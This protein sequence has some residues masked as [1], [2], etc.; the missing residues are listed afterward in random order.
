M[1]ALASGFVWAVCFGEASLHRFELSH[2]LILIEECVYAMAHVYY[3]RCH[4]FQLDEKES[5]SRSLFNP[6]AA[7]HQ[8]IAAPTKKARPFVYT[9]LPNGIRFNGNTWIVSNWS[10]FRM[11]TLVSIHVIRHAIPTLYL[12]Y[13]FLYI[14]FTYLLYYVHVKYEY[15]IP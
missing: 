9:N 3:I 5:G 10:I 12:R 1:C 11:Y 6:I 4:R 7:Y 8:S 13:L 2:R 14:S 15:I